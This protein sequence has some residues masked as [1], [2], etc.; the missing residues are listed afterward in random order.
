MGCQKWL[1]FCAPIFLTY[2]WWSR[3]CDNQTIVYK[4]NYIPSSHAF[5]HPHAVLREDFSKKFSF[6]VRVTASGTSFI[7]SHLELPRKI[8]CCYVGL[9]SKWLQQ[10]I[11]CFALWFHISSHRLRTNEGKN[12]RNSEMFGVW[13]LTMFCRSFP[14]HAPMLCVSSHIFDGTV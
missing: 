4:T 12:E 7:V 14:Y 11:W 13:F 6:E 1:R 3:W 8:T 9:K 2:F 10:V 5:D